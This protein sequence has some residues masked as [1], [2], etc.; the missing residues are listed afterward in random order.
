MS[1]Q[2]HFAP[3]W[4]DN[5]LNFAIETLFG[6]E[7]GALL[8]DEAR[9]EEEFPQKNMIDGVKMEPL[10]SDALTPELRKEARKNA[11]DIE[12]NIKKLVR[13]LARQEVRDKLTKE[14]GGFKTNEINSFK[15]QFERMKV[16][17]QVKNGTSLVDRNEIETKLKEMEAKSKIL[18]NTLKE[19]QD[20][21]DQV[22]QGNKEHKQQR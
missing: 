19:K 10:D 9:C 16:L 15:G 17:Y 6:N 7:V 8:V 14:F 18:Q 20:E 5:L 11:N 21:F 2:L 3:K 4:T 12:R 1:K 13:V 22:T